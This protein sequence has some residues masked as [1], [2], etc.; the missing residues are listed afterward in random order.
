MIELLLENQLKC[1][2]AG[3]YLFI[4]G[5]IDPEKTKAILENRYDIEE[6]KPPEPDSE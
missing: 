1:G 6:I 4:W 2:V 5:W 3:A